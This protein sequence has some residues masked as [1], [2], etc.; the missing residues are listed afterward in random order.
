MKSSHLKS[1]LSIIF[2]S[3]VIVSANKSES[4]EFKTVH[5]F[6]TSGQEIDLFT[7]AQ[8]TNRCSG[9]FGAVARFLPS[10]GEKDKSVLLSGKFLELSFELLTKN[11]MNAAEQIG[12]RMLGDIKYYTGVYENEMTQH[13]RNTGSILSEVIEREL[14]W[15]KEAANNFF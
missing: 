9:L 8:V 3:I 4:S 10:G 11:R 1:V 7:T 5:E 15:C 14:F 6:L 13:Q 2:C 12:E